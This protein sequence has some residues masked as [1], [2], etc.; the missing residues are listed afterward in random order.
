MYYIHYTLYYMSYT[1][2]I[3][4]HTLCICACR[5]VCMSPHRYTLTFLCSSTIPMYFLKK[6]YTNHKIVLPCFLSVSIH[7]LNEL[8]QRWW[9]S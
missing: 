8:K 9:F 6:F 2:Y 4:M 3:Y 5:C 1:I 7:V